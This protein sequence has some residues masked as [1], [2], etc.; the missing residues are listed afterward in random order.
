[1][2]LSKKKGDFEKNTLFLN[3]NL[4]KITAYNREKL[5]LGAS[6]SLS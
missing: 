3:K 6:F 2:Q 1:L 5:A 4:N